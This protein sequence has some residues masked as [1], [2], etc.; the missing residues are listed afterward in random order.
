[1]DGPRPIGAVR[2][3]RL[4]P[5]AG[6]RNGKMTTNDI[7]GRIRPRA[8]IARNKEKV[9]IN[10]NGSLA[11]NK[12]HRGPGMKIRK[13]AHKTAGTEVGN[14]QEKKRTR[15]NGSPFVSWEGR[16][17]PEKYRRGIGIT[18]GMTTG[19]SRKNTRRRKKR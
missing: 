2:K 16:R 18:S 13:I 10:G 3:T 19:P 17:R 7:S 4:D 1:M 8:S 14:K 6:S 9:T 5:L 11:P 12:S 15:T